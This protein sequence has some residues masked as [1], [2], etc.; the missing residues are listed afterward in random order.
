MA[1]I[2]EVKQYGHDETISAP[3]VTAN[4]E[5]KNINNQL[6]EN[7][8]VR[9]TENKLHSSIEDSHLFVGSRQGRVS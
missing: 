8:K 5:Y 6:S 4:Y 7:N 1:H 2:E 9:T 3:S